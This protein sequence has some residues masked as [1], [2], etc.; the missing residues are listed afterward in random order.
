M[1]IL[2]INNRTENWKTVQ[3]F[4]RLSLSDAAKVRLVKH[5]E[6]KETAAA[7]EICME[8]F[9]RGMRDYDKE[10]N[11]GMDDLVRSYRCCFSDLRKDICAFQGLRPLKNRN[12]AVPASTDDRKR[13]ANNLKNTEV[14]IVLA[15]PSRIFIGEAKDESD[16]GT[17][18]DLVLV[19]QLIRQYVA[20]KVLVDLLGSPIKHVVPF[21]IGKEK[22]TN[23]RQVKFMVKQE[24]LRECNVLTWCELR[25]LCD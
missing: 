25:R 21:V 7:G 17:N 23:K 3:H 6:P 15:T 13:L 2:G 5:L 11:V 16:L 8:L 1:G 9:W 10:H 4:H 18:S 20:V 24:W 22:L 19:H 12:Y 14:D